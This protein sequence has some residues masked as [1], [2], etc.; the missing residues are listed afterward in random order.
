MAVT[1]AERKDKLPRQA[2]RPNWIAI[3]SRPVAHA[4]QR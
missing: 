1:R 2:P 4:P 3:Q